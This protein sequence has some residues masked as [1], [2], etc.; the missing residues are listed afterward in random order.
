MASYFYK[1][2]RPF[3]GSRFVLVLART[4]AQINVRVKTIRSDLDTYGM[5]RAIWHHYLLRIYCPA[6]PAPG[7]AKPHAAITRIRGPSQIR[8]YPGNALRL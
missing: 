1:L 8:R 4:V 6:A 2:S 7:Q 5:P 3:F